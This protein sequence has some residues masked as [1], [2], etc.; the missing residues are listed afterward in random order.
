[1]TMLINFNK[2]MSP[3]LAGHYI[4]SHTYLSKTNQFALML[5]LFIPSTLATGVSVPLQDDQTHS[6]ISVCL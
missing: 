6:F 4:H 2:A 5:M 1:M 3:V